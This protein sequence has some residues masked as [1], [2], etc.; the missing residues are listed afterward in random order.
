MTEVKD[1]EMKLKPTAKEFIPKGKIIGVV[2]REARSGSLSLN[3][4]AKEF[5]PK[6]SPVIAPL[7]P[8][9]MPPF[10]PNEPLEGNLQKNLENKEVTHKKPKPAKPPKNVYTINCMLMYK[11][12]CN[13]KPKDMKFVDIPLKSKAERTEIEQ[14]P[15]EVDNLEA[16]RDLRILLNKLSR[17]NFPRIADSITNNFQYTKEILEGLVVSSLL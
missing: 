3:P 15:E 6:S 5:I 12:K 13:K 11:K 9:F 7:P 14:I 10:I 1:T 16:L 17:D 8:P 2:N 4:A